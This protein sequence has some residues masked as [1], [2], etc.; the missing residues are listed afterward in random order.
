MKKYI[1]MLYPIVLGVVGGGILSLISWDI[2][3][4]IGLGM[5]GT[6]GAIWNYTLYFINK[7]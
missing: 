6:L 1:E 5:L 4:V 2:Q 3:W 7:L